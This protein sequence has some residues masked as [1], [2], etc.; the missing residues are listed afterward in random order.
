MLWNDK[1]LNIHH[2]PK[3]INVKLLNI[4][5]L[6]NFIYTIF[7]KSGFDLKRIEK[8]QSIKKFQSKNQIDSKIIEDIFEFY[9]KNKPFYS[10]DIDEP[11]KI[12]GMWKGLLEKGRKTQLDNI[13]NNEKEEYLKL[14]EQMFFNEL[15]DG[16]SNYHSYD[17][18]IFY[19]SSQFLEEVKI[20]EKIT[21]KTSEDLVTNNSW[22]CWGLS[23]NKGIVKY[24]DPSHG[25]SAFT[26]LN[27][28]RIP[29]VL[30]L[31]S[32]YGGLAEKIMIWSKNKI[33]ICLIDIPLNLTNAYAYLHR[34]FGKEKILLISTKEELSKF[35]PK[36][37][38]GQIVLIPTILTPHI[39]TNFNFDLVHN[40]HSFSEM[41]LHSIDYYLKKL[42]T[43]NV[44]FLI[45]TNVNIP[46]SIADGHLEIR[47]SEFP[48]PKFFK[49][50]TRFSDGIQTRYVTSIYVNE[51]YFSS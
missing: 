40:M 9:K 31:G 38:S 19:C 4:S 46:S 5:I 20:F 45:E 18:N 37:N 50:L 49:L 2:N 8:I 21:G 42:T 35:D 43:K 29:W 32:G 33:N 26:T 7:N 3:F 36:K 48:I 27:L 6:K 10:S 41:D 15:I 11:L 51:K 12:A 30:D 44:S 24:T 34:I 17:K 39:S 13:K 1:R 25:I 16:L 28:D 22:S 47:T 14:Q 23:T